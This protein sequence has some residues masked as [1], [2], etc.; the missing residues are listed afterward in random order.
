MNCFKIFLGLLIWI[1]S[2]Q[3]LSA[4]EPK[5]K[6]VMDSCGCEGPTF[7]KPY[8]SDLS[9]RN[10]DRYKEK[11]EESFTTWSNDTMRQQVKSIRFIHFDSIP[12][13][14]Q[15]FTNVE[16]IIISDSRINGFDSVEIQGL[17]QFPKLRSL[18]VQ[19]SSIYINPKAKWLQNIE[20]LHTEKSKIQGIQSFSSMPMLREVYMAY[21]G[22]GEFPKD[23]GSLKYLKNLTLGAYHFGK[24]DLKEIDIR[25]LPCLEELT[26][27]TWYD[28]LNG[29]P[30]GLESRK[31]KV[32][33][34]HHQKLTIEEKEILKKFKP[35]ED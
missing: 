31:L 13:R 10:S 14:F 35:V 25:Q 18:V 32:L 3:A 7:L 5:N 23:V 17:D 20:R 29:I 6:A 12:Q 22:F 24:I 11:N 34:V 19:G 28:S 9:F 8:N 26:L 21:S 1:F 16:Q 4:Q 15:V 30:R 2:G 33:K 27:Q